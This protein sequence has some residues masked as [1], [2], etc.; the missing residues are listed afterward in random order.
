[1]YHPE[2]MSIWQ[3]SKS[4]CT[5]VFGIHSVVTKVGFSTSSLESCCMHMAVRILIP[6]FK[7]TLDYHSVMSRNGMQ[8]SLHI[9]N[10]FPNPMTLN[11]LLFIRFPILY[12]FLDINHRYLS[13]HQAISTLSRNNPHPNEA[14]KVIWNNGQQSLNIPS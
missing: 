2:M 4:S 12:K 9:W 13:Y 7:K 5:H 3:N 1:M 11:F 10:I 6:I 14:M 8:Y